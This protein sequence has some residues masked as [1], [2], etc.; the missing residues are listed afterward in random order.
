MKKFRLGIAVLIGFIP[1]TVFIIRRG[2]IPL[3]QSQRKD[4]NFDENAWDLEWEE[5]F[6]NVH[7]RLSEFLNK[8]EG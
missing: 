1:V 4:P 6:C 7:P 5:R 8:I 3:Y 2:Y